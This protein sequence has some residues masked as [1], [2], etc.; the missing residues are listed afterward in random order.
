MRCGHLRFLDALKRH[1]WPGN[2]RELE[3]CLERLVALCDGEIGK[4]DVEG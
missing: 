4:Q 1:R 2:V 3:H